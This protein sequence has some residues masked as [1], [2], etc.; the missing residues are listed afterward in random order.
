LRFSQNEKLWIKT[1]IQVME[2]IGENSNKVVD[3][4][5]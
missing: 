1:R 3:N 2:L 4:M 5:W